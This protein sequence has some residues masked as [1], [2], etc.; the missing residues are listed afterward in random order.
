MLNR[1]GRQFLSSAILNSL[2]L[3]VGH[4]LTQMR[5]YYDARL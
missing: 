3:T 1:A 5:G 2:T 4:P